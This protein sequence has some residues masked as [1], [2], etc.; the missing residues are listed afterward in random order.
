MI[1]DVDKNG[2]SIMTTNKL[3][4][5]ASTFSTK[6]AATQPTLTTT[7]LA[8][9]DVLEVNINQIGSTVAGAG[10]KVY[11]IGYPS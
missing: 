7:T 10:L 6:D 4:I 1:A 8:D 5:D 9:D 2:A 3:E 11:L